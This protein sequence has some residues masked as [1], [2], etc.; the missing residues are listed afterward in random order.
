VGWACARAGGTG[1]PHGGP[2]GQDYVP[3][4]PLSARRFNIVLCAVVSGEPRIFAVGRALP[5]DLRCI[6]IF[7]MRSAATALT[8]RVG[9]VLLVGCAFAVNDEGYMQRLEPVFVS[10]LRP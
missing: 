4:L 1:E 8:V 10:P 5:T 6:P 7:L 2:I 9:R 3:G